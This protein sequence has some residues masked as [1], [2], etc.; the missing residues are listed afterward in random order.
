MTKKGKQEPLPG[1]ANRQIGELHSKALEYAAIRDERMDLSKKEV[2][3][4]DDLLALMHKHKKD[5]YV[6]E[7][8]EIY[9]ETSEETVKVKVHKTETDEAVQ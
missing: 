2:T 4:K 9:I 3:L 7:G 6:F 5:S 1:M 8:I